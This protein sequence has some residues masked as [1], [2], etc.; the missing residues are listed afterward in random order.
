MAHYE[1]LP[2]S[3]DA[4]RLGLG[5]DELFEQ[6]PS[7]ARPALGRGGGALRVE[8]LVFALRLLTM[9]WA[10]RSRRSGGSPGSAPLTA[11]LDKV[12][13]AAARMQL[14]GAAPGLA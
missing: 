8:L 7:R 12:E 6:F 5:E 10:A 13:R 2:I 3:A 4:Y 9:Q 11:A 1:H 14:H